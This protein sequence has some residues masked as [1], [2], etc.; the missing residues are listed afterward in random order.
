[1]PG[2]QFDSITKTF[3]GV[4]ALSDVSFSVDPSSVHA[5]LGENGAGKSTLLKILSGVYRPDSGQILVEGKSHIFRNTSEA[6]HNGIAVIYQELH[7]V[8]EMT[9]AENLYLGHFPGKWGWVNR[10]AMR[11]AALKQLQWLGEDISPRTKISSLAIGQ[12]QMVEIAKSL[13]RSAKVIAFDEPTSSLSSRETDKLFAVIEQLRKQGRVIMYVSHRMDEIFQICDAATVLRDGRHVETFENLKTVTRDTL[14]QRMVGRSIT[15]VFNYRARPIGEPLLEIENLSGAA[16]AAPARCS[17]RRGEI[18]GFFGLV[19]AGRSELMRLIYGADKPFAGRLHLGSD[20]YRPKNPSSSIRK[21]VVLCPEDRKK[22]G[23]VPVRSVQENLNISGRRHFSPLKIFIAP[24]R[25]RQ[26][27]QAFVKQLAIK[28]PSLN[29]PIKLLSGGNQQKVILAR[30]LCEH[31]KVILL[32]EP[33]RGIDVGAKSEIYNIIYGLAEKGVAVLVVSSE[34]PEVMGVCDRIAVMRQGKIA[35][36]IERADATQEKLL[37]LALPRGDDGS[38]D[39]IP[40][41][42]GI[43]G[44]GRGEGLGTTLR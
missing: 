22:D 8:P 14:V 5:L 31:P 1:M 35:G 29:Q 23:I 9:V 19:G 43:P 24:R 32:D 12:R 30:W 25:E 11:D 2:L 33:T 6:I 36:V 7:L 18:L 40:P 4:K 10:P 3:P 34:L 27:A 39:G 20:I 41:S 42:P 28:T 15:D 17:V 13:A 21:G 37:E 16:L 26:N 44:E 38:A